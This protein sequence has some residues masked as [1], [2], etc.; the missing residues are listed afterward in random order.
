MT[1]F[2]PRHPKLVVMMMMI[3]I[4]SNMSTW[5]LARHTS[6]DFTLCARSGIHTLR[7]PHSVCI[8]IVV[9]FLS[10]TPVGPLNNSKLFSDILSTAVNDMGS[11]VD[12]ILISPWEICDW[13]V[14]TRISIYVPPRPQCKWYYYWFYKMS[15]D[16]L[17]PMALFD[18]IIL[19]SVMPTFGQRMETRER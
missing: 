5:G 15:P 10:W 11:I 17:W 3:T 7:N 14:A 6:N 16:F 18:D 8:T 1:N 12:E 13:H 4:Q 9:M 2:G 19:T